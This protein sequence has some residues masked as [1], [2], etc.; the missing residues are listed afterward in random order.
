M[1]TVAHWLVVGGTALASG[2]Y[3]GAAAAAKPSMNQIVAGLEFDDAKVVAV[4]A[5]R[6]LVRPGVT[7]S[8]AVVLVREGVIEAVGEDLAVPEGARVVEGSV[9]CAGFID[10]WSALG[11]ESG[12]LSDPS[13]D[14]ATR[15]A[16]GLDPYEGDHLRTQALA[17]GVTSVR[18]QGGRSAAI[19]GLGSRG[20][21]VI[22]LNT[23]VKRPGMYE[24]EMGTTL[25]QII[26][27]MAGGMA[28]G[29]SFKAVQ[30][31]GPLG[32]ILPA[33]LLD[34]PL[35]FEAMATVNGIVGHAGIVVYSQED[36]LVEVARELMAFCAI[37]SCG[38]C[39]PCRIGAVRGTELFDQ[40]MSD[41]VT[42]DRIHLLGELCETMEYGSLCGMGSMTPA[43]IESVME[44]FPEEFERYRSQARVA[45]AT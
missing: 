2:F 40:M 7:L 4:R 10:P 1:K 39:F 19:G 45:V 18:L 32:G 6:V 12:V 30:V 20:T 11:L 42:E 38:K 33:S 14:A 9:C 3:D 5:K 27:D 35:D 22:S 17:A 15:T 41:G 21:K 31:G 28:D 24:V 43:P 29:Q 26:F 13:P 25:R 23:R 37:E 16:D 8:D 44:Y 36:D 34:T